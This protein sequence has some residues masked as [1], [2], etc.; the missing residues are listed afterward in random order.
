M[1]STNKTICV[2]CG[3]EFDSES[4]AGTCPHCGMVLSS[5]TNQNINQDLP[6]GTLLGGYEIIRT[7]GYGGMG[8]VYLA[9]QKSMQRQI[10]LKV[11]N[12]SVTKDAAAVE[13]FLTEIRNTGQIHHP[14]MVNAFD[15]GCENG[16]YFFVDIHNNHIIHKSRNQFFVFR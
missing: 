9:E 10:A 13:Q 4:A 8:T 15:A 11:L 1:E 16:I 7:L 14:H 3:N 6:A 5:N 12:S 2:K